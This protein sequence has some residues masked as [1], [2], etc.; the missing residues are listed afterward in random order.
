MASPAALPPASPPPG[1]AQLGRRLLLLR[2][3]ARSGERPAAQGG[4]GASSQH[5]A[6]AATPPS[7]RGRC[8]ALPSPALSSSF[9]SPPP[10]PQRRERRAVRAGRA[11]GAVPEGRWAR[12]GGRGGCA[13]PRRGPSACRRWGRRSRPEGGGP[14]RRGVWC[15][16]VPRLFLGKVHAQT[17]WRLVKA[18]VSIWVKQVE[19]ECLWVSPS[20][21]ATRSARPGSAS[22]RPTRTALERSADD[23]TCLKLETCTHLLSLRSC[24]CLHDSSFPYKTNQPS[25]NSSAGEVEKLTTTKT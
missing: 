6:A 11:F 13:V 12:G 22:L 15:P 23:L 4:R 21:A 1:S 16:S 2:P 24:W 18:C 8:P 10:A 25:P 20:G 5:P 7:A 3:P 14:G 17:L 19:C 9:S